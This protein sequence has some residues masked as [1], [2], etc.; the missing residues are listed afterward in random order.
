MG[1]LIRE[2][3]AT[4]TWC[5]FSISSR[6]WWLCVTV[7]LEYNRFDLTL[8][9]YVYLTLFR[10]GLFGV[11]HGNLSHIFYIDE[12]WY[13]YTLPKGDTK[14]VWI[15]WDTPFEFCWHQRFFSG[16]Q[17]ILLY[18]ERQIYIAFWYII[19]NSFN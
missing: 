5:K 17:L 19:S 11:A 12:T 2:F 14:N 8:I 6:C 15:T 9:W 10:S 4:F 18:Q 7:T 13:S 16:S 1:N 3:P